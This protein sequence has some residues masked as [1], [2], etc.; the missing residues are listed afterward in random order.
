MRA[1]ANDTE[2][3]FQNCQAFL[4]PHEF[5]F[6]SIWH[7]SFRFEARDHCDDA[8]LRRL[9]ECRDLTDDFGFGHGRFVGDGLGEVNSTRMPK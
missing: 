5:W 7:R 2:I 1:A 8:P 3:S 9:R 4:S 6:H